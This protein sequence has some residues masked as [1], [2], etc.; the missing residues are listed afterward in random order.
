[1]SPFSL[2][3][4]PF[5]KIAILIEWPPEM[6]DETLTD[7]SSFFQKIQHKNIDGVN[8]FIQSINSLTVVYDTNLISYYSLKQSLEK[9]Y[10]ESF[11]EIQQDYY[12][13]NIP[14]CYDPIFGVDLELISK[15]NKLP[16]NEIVRLHASAIY[17]VYSIGFL[18]GFLYLGGLDKRIH[19]D[20]KA[21]PKLEV[22]KGAVAIGGKQT[23]IYP[24][25]SPG[26]WQIIGNTPI[27]LF[28]KTKAVP[29]F[30]KPGDKIQIVQI[31]YD[32]YEQIQKQLSLNEFTLKKEVFDD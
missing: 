18:P 24:K 8:E 13:W 29:C 17:R 15:K 10:T 9:I 4:K 5:G 1:M 23:G 2:T 26:G 21:T 31:S 27:S 28:D 22:P 3:Y 6:N 14:V 20:R 11:N 25:S 32:E 7:I 12:L 19:I 30:A 16:V